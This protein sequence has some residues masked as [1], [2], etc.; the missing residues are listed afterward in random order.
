MEVLS[1]NAVNTSAGAISIT[2]TGAVGLKLNPG[3]FITAESAGGM[4]R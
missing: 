3:A 2:T 4:T 1:T